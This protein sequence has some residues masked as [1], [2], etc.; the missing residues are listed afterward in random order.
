MKRIKW[1]T[2]G[3][4]AKK[5]WCWHLFSSTHC[6]FLPIIKAGSQTSCIFHMDIMQHTCFQMNVKAVKYS[7]TSQPFKLIISIGKAPSFPVGLRPLCIINCTCTCLCSPIPWSDLADWGHA[8]LRFSPSP[9]ND[10]VYVA[11]AQWARAECLRTRTQELGLCA[12]LQ[13]QDRVR[14]LLVSY[15]CCH[16]WPQTKNT[17][18]VLSY[19]SGNQEF[20][21]DF[22][23]L[24]PRCWQD[25]LPS[26]GTR[27]NPFPCYLQLLE[28]ACLP[29]LMAFLP[30]PKP[31]RGGLSP[32]MAS[33]WPSRRLSPSTFNDPCD[34]IGSHW[35][36]HY[37]I[38]WI[39][40]L[41]PLA[42]LIPLCHLTEQNHRFQG[43]GRRHLE[44][45][46]GAYS[47][48]HAEGARE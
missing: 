42:T 15:C 43:L 2:L 33:L 9:E 5:E 45:G 19:S 11:G 46:S 25:C 38:R 29:C 40:I 16:M 20:E 32:H 39:T 22:M 44:R 13:T 34:Y 12:V 10:G 24:N 26:G 35:I 41:I 23:R 31:E 18:N 28:P 6:L 17:T 47:A 14:W 7:D 1:H 4:S 36:T 3:L 37:E 48:W 30:S 27:K 8:S 21:M